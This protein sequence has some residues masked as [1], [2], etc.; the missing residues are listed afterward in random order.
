M[1]DKKAL[2]ILILFSYWNILQAQQ[3][4]SPEEQIP[5]ACT[6]SKNSDPA[7]GDDDFVQTFFFVIPE[8]WKKPVYIRVFDPEVGA[9]M[10]KII[11]HSIA[12]PGSLYTVVTRLIQNLQLKVPILQEILK[13]E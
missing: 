10:M 13:V 4:P 5:F 3:I 1:T 7:W 11:M 9:D 2:L 12:K 8:S 6:F